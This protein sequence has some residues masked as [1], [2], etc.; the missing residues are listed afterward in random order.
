LLRST[1]NKEEALR[2]LDAL[3]PSGTL[4]YQACDD[5]ICYPTSVPVFFTLDLE[6]F[7][8]LRANR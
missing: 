8:R 4:D 2:E 3:T 5:I 7:D 6:L 1:E